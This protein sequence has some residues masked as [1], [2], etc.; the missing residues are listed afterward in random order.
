MEKPG[1]YLTTGSSQERPCLPAAPATTVDAAAL[2]SEAI[3]KTVCA[4]M[5]CGW[6][7]LRTP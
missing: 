4:L 5:V 1:R 2:E 7:T 3:W 6:P